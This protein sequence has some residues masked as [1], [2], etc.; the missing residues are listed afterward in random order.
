MNETRSILLAITAFLIVRHGGD[1]GAQPLAINPS[2]A[3]SDINNPSS[4]NP[5]ARASDVLNPSAVNPAAAAS[6]IPQPGGLPLGSGDRVPRIGQQ[7]SAPLSS[8]TVERVPRSRIT[9][10][11]IE[12]RWKREREPGWSA[13][14]GVE[15]WQELRDNL[16]TCWLVPGGTVGSSTV[17]RF[18]ISSVGELRGPPMITGTNVVPKEMSARYR[19][20]SFAVLQRCLP[21]RPTAEF[22]AIL[23]DTV[24]HLRLVNDAP[25]PSRNLG[26][27]MTIFARPRLGG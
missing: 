19:E 26:P 17:L 10:R 24:L 16:A 3:A 5:A 27:W 1:A 23:H 15:T 20:A 9:A 22:G 13:R 21:V 12:E 7:R 2:A 25:F 6:Q 18:M 14:P 8:L 4:I 11:E